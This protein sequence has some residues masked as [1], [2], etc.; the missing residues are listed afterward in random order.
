M[1]ATSKNPSRDIVFRVEYRVH[2]DV[3]EHR[4]CAALKDAF[5]GLVGAGA[6]AMAMFW[7]EEYYESAELL[8]RVYT[9]LINW[10]VDGPVHPPD[11]MSRFFARVT[12]SVGSGGQV[13]KRQWSTPLEP[14]YVFL[15]RHALPDFAEA[16]LLSIDEIIERLDGKVASVSQVGTDFSES[17][18]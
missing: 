4:F 3:G 12:A 6:P 14:D 9:L 16:E 18:C 15:K 13:M 10:P 2:F 17:E 7:Y 8:M 5:V 11:L 1:D